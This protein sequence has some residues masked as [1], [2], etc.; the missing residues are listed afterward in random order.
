MRY[1]MLAVFI[2]LCVGISSCAKTEAEVTCEK[3]CDPRNVRLVHEVAEPTNICVCWGRNKV[4]VDKVE[5]LTSEHCKK[6]CGDEGIEAL[7]PL[8]G[9]CW[10][11]E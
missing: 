5:K 4:F 7:A 6:L 11:G 8:N 1:L 2:G 9:V 10:C 3:T